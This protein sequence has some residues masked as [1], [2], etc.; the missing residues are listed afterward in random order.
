MNRGPEGTSISEKAKGQ[1]VVA[2]MISDFLILII[3][4]NGIEIAIVLYFTSVWLNPHTHSQSPIIRG[5]ESFIH[6]V[7]GIDMI[8]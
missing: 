3:K 5:V 1:K 6:P 4:I 8:F 7:C 2:Y